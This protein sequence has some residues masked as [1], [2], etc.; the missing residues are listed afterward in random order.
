MTTVQTPVPRRFRLAAVC[1]AL[2]ALTFLQQPGRIVADTKLDLVVDPGGFL[3][4]ASQMWDAEGFFGQV[5]NQAYGYLFPMG[6]FFW[7]GDHLADPWVVQRLWWSL[8]LSVAFVGMATLCRELGIGSLGVQTC[9]GLAFAL[10][11]R[12]LTVIGP[13]SIEVWPSAVAPWVLVPLVIGLR[14]GSPRRQAALSAVAVAAVGGVNAVATFAVIPLGAVWLLVAPRGPRRRA[15]MRW[16]PPL[17]L[18]GTLWWLVPLFLLGSVSPPFLDFI[19][20]SA[21]TT[22]TATLFDALRGTSNWVPYVSNDAVAGR[23]LFTNTAVI[24]N[25]GVVLLAG[26]AGLLTAP[27][28]LRLF[29]VWSV[30][31]GLFLVTLGHTGNV[32]GWGAG[33]IQTALDGALA[34]LRNTHK[35]DV[36]LR[37]P[38]VLGAA[39]LLTRLLERRAVARRAAAAS[40]GPTTRTFAIGLTVLALVGATS[41]AWTGGL[42]N[43]GSFEST[44]DYWRQAAQYLDDSARGSSLLVPSSAFGDY[45]WGS[46]GDELM[47]AIASSPWAVRNS[48]PLT[49]PGTIRYMDSIS[50]VLDQGRRAP[51]LAESLRRAGVGQVVVRNDLDPSVAAGRTEAV[52]ETLRSSPGLTRAAQFGPV[53]DGTSVI[54]LGSQRSFS[55]GGWQSSHPAVE[56]WQVDDLPTSA[57][58]QQVG[59]TATVVGAADT[60]PVLDDLGLLPDQ[61]VVL[62]QDRSAGRDAI[63]PGGPLILT[64]GLRR[65]EVA[66]GSVDQLRSASLTQND[67]YSRQRAVHDYTTPRDQRWTS[68]PQLR[69]AAATT[70]SSSRAEA[71]N[72]LPLVPGA[73]AWSAFDGDDRTSWIANSDRGWVGLRLDR[74][75]DVGTIRVVVDAAPGEFVRLRVRTDQGVVT[76]SAA[77]RKP[78]SFDVGTVGEIRVEAVRTAGR[79]ASIAEV[80]VPG[81]V[82][83]RPL[84]LPEP[85]R[86]WGAADRIVLGADLGDRPSCVVVVGVDRCRAD[87]GAQ[88]EDTFHLDR[89]LTVSAAAG[90]SAGVTTSPLGGPSTEAFLQDGLPMRVT[91]SST[92]DTDVRA[93]ITRAIDRDVD[94]GWISEPGDTDPSIDLRW[95]AR[96]TLS[97]IRLQ[98]SSDLPASRV[99]RVRLE[100]D[101]GTTRDVVLR[102]GVGRFEPVQTRHVVVHLTSSR[103]AR[104]FDPSG[105]SRTLPVGVSELRF[106]GTPTSR[107]DVS[108]RTVELPCGSGPTITIDGTA[109]PTAVTTSRAAVATGATATAT[110]CGGRLM[111]LDAGRHRVVIS[112]SPTFLA[113]RTVLTNLRQRAAMPAGGSL[114]V[115][116]QNANDGFSG[117]ADGRAV[118]AVTVNGWQRG[119]VVPDGVTADVAESFPLDRPYRTGLGVG[120]ASALLL[121]ATAALRGR[122]R[123][124]PEGGGAR[125]GSRA[126]ALT[127]VGML[128]ALGLVGGTA[129]LACGLL[130]ALVGRLVTTR[131]GS[132]AAWVAVVL[133]PALGCY[134]WWSVGSHPSP[135]VPWALPQLC[136]A[137]SLGVVVGA[138]SRRPGISDMNGTSTVR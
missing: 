34:P 57:K 132:P 61:S 130:G 69:G 94:T 56:I 88:G 28:R 138:V 44:P 7:L 27:A 116:D 18:L 15:M 111:S 102:G 122:R 68:V 91:A 19:E 137:A 93:G 10:S 37:I 74:V 6:P 125:P 49:P 72:F 3:A 110:V 1:L 128:A 67:P 120:A 85:P 48:V 65:Q 78:V 31:L 64:D 86:G 22:S 12:M 8:L 46:T 11:P 55:S 58:V 103:D 17:V 5:Q 25:S 98:T 83:S 131:S 70:S 133:L 41:P 60:L 92:I 20:S 87:A 95:D 127:T 77:G 118:D 108:A 14:R 117:T 16:W 135:L 26:L 62:A 112:A 136:V 104:D 115:R 75:R 42:A 80:V 35:F 54:D 73:H 21:T 109:Y 29:L 50:A 107:P 30:L 23:L 119:W 134:F 99:A 66:F 40:K 45:L 36:V 2:T 32:S 24:V 76:R 47:Q 43:R 33:S 123:D 90:Y 96:Q 89:E 51:G 13:S 97:T 38:L 113:G 63:R 4:R 52:Y 106:P 9:A 59:D 101:D 81:V 39:S 84:V 124:L 129:G 114:V 105:A 53:L 79:L 121:L 100:L 71:D 82:P 126:A